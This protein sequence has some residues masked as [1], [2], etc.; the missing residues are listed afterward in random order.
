MFALSY[1]SGPCNMVLLVLVT[2]LACL[3]CLLFV[4]FLKPRT[5]RREAVAEQKAAVLSVWAA[6]VALLFTGSLWAAC[7]LGTWFSLEWR[8][9]ACLAW[10]SLYSPCW[11]GSRYL[12]VS[13]STGL[14]L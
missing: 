8:Q 7:S 14:G 9:S 2:G 10:N 4:A 6:F 1:V 12:S 13:A 5:R 3:F 11:P